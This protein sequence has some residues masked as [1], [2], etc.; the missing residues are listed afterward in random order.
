MTTTHHRTFSKNRN[1]F[2][3]LSIVHGK[4]PV[5]WAQGT[6]R[7]FKLSYGTSKFIALPI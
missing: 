6:H 5:D 3:M 7:D 1:L 2:Q 4:E